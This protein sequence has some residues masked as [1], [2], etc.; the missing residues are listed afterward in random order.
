MSVHVPAFTNKE[1]F[2]WKR[3]GCLWSS[4]FQGADGY[5]SIVQYS[6][7][8]KHSFILSMEVHHYRFSPL[9]GQ[10]CF[11]VQNTIQKVLAGSNDCWNHFFYAWVDETCPFHVWFRWSKPVWYKSILPDVVNKPLWLPAPGTTISLSIEITQYLWN[12]LLVVIG[13]RLTSCCQKGFLGCVW[14]CFI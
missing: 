11:W 2:H 10:L 14:Q 1:K 13:L 7:V 3:D 6:S 9:D 8:Y 12:Y 4:W 5:F